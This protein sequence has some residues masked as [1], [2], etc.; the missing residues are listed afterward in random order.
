MTALDSS[1]WAYNP[2][3]SFYSHTIDQSLRFEDGDSAYLYK[4]YGSSAG[5]DTSTWTFS[6]WLK[7]GDPNAQ[8]VIWAG[9]AAG[10]GYATNLFYIQLRGDSQSNRLDITWRQNSSTT[11]GMS[12]NGAFRDLSA[13]MHIVLACDTTQATASNRLRLYIN[14]TEETSFSSDDRSTIS[15]SSALPINANSYDHT[16]GR[17]S[18]SASAYF[19]GYMAEINFVDGSQLAPTSFG[20]TKAGIWIPKDFSG[21]H[22]TTGFYLPFKEAGDLGADGAYTTHD[23]FGDSSAFA[24]Y[25]FDG[26]IVDAGGNYNGTATNVTFTDGIVGTQAGVFNGSSSKWVA[27]THLFGANATASSVSVSGW[28]QVSSNSQYLIADGYL[29]TGG[30][31]F[32]I[33]TSGGKLVAGTGDSSGGN[34]IGITSSTSVTDG[35]WHHFAFTKSVSGG[36]ATG[37]LWVDGNYEGSDTT[38]STGAFANETA[39]GHRVDANGYYSCTLDQIRIFNRVLTDAEVQ[40]LAGGYGLDTSGVGNHFNP[41][42]LQ[43]TDVVLDSPTNNHSTFNPLEGE[44][45]LLTAKVTLL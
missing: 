43:A 34:N 13:W 1:Q 40:Q 44:S 39:F 42:N 23:I 36:T 29:G 2:S 7:I 18:Y 33:N 45:Y 10:A 22:G 5:G 3:T 8:K 20:E 6:V 26:S 41:V 12:T 21:S 17:S 38:T 24:T 19:D 15:Q 35:E 37:K 30:K 4:T 31:Y 9:S 11:R 14:G 28:F 25:L 16:I 27:G 32:A